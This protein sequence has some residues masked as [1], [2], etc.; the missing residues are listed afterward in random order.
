MARQAFQSQS[1]EPVSIL[2]LSLARH[3][4]GHDISTVLDKAWSDPK[5]ST[6]VSSHF[7]NVGYNLDPTPTEASLTQL[8][9]ALQERRWDG[10]MLGWCVRG[11]PEFT[12]LYE[13]V[14]TACLE[15]TIRRHKEDGTKPKIMFCTGPQDLVNATLRNFP[16][17]DLE[18][19]AM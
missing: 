5:V 18:T 10:V 7:D 9:K 6:A 8:N 2:T 13:A 14:V 19:M 4:V 12:E 1:A 11:H 15:E 16:V 3:L 17:D